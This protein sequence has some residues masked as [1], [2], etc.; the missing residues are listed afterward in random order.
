VAGPVFE[1]PAVLTAQISLDRVREESMN[2]D[3]AG[4]YSRPD[5]FRLLRMNETR[6]PE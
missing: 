5:V 6:Q 4:H 2:L 1:A 3:V